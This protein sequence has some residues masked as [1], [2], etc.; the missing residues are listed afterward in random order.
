MYKLVIAVLISAFLFHSAMSVKADMMNKV[1][2]HT[3][4]IDKACE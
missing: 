4:L 3:Q 2:T 1:I